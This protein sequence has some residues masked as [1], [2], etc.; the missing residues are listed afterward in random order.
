MALPT[1]PIPFSDMGFV[2][3]TFTRQ[4]IDWLIG[5]VQY[6]IEDVEAEDPDGVAL[7][8]K[9]KKLLEP[10][11]PTCVCPRCGQERDCV[12]SHAF[13]KGPGGWSCWDCLDPDYARLLASVYCGMAGQMRRESLRLKAEVDKLRALLRRALPHLWL[14]DSDLYVDIDANL[15]Q[16]V[17]HG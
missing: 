3:A 6:A 17:Q 8:A 10:L 14:R 11:E 4:E 15:A 12:Y 7:V 1:E 9:L 16:E 5:Y 2:H 13:G